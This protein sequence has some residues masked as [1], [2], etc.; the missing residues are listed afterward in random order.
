MSSNQESAS[1]WLNKKLAKAKGAYISASVLTILS[2]GCFV[3]FCWYLSEFAASWLNNGLILP[4]ALLYASVFLTGRYILAHFASLFNYKAGNIIVSKIKKKLFPILLNNNKLDSVSS[5]LFVTRVSDDFKPYFAFFI[6]YSMASFLVS[7]LLLVVS[8]WIEKWVGMLLLISLLV[9]PFQ[10][11]V[12]G[13][14]AEA[15]HKKHINLFMKYS[16]VFYNRLQTI[17]EIVNLDNF[18]PQYRFLSEKSKALNKA[19]TNVMQVA[20]LSSAV[21]ELFVTICIA[22]IAIYLGMSL[23]GIM[24]GPNYG[25]SYDFRTALF[26]LT[27]SPYFFFYLRKFVSAYHD[28]NRALASAKLVMPI[29]NEEIDAT[30]ADTNE[31]FSSLEI[32]NL[33]FAYP[34]SPV[35]VLH[36]IS[37]SLPAKGLVLVKGISGSGKSTLLKIITGSLFPQ[38]GTVSINGKDSAWSHQWLKV[39]S[40]YMNQFPFIFDGTLHYNIFLKKETDRRDQYPDFLDKI[41]NKKENGWLTELSHNGKQLSGGEKQLVTL[42]RMMLYPKPIAILDEPTANLDA[43]TVEIILPQ[44][45]KLAE[46]RLVII[47]SHEKMFDTVADTIVNLNWGEQMKYE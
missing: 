18:K 6:P 35:K 5:T 15:L 9:I 29:L 13:V 20:I 21:L 34:D 8:F 31:V 36:N 42:A 14:G 1:R 23:L 38:D 17:A 19:T 33:N 10:M 25:N 39:N 30:L 43:D 32:N 24:T 28:R 45:M 12:I 40:S 7:G 44:I 26:L 4:N 3:I 2:A 46:N 41:L 11:I 16:A 37:L 47:A 27:L 22:A